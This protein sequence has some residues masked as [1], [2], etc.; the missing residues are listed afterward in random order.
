MT[1]TTRPLRWFRKAFLRIGQ[2]LL[3][4]WG[5]LAIYYSNLPWA[6]ARVAL[7]AAFGAFAVWALWVTRRPRVRWVFAGV[8]GAVVI[9]EIS[10]PPSNDR[11]WRREVAV[12][13]RAVIEGDRVRLTRFRNFAYRSADDFDV[14]YEEREISLAHLVSVDLFVSYWMPGPVAHTF[15]SFDFDDGTPPVCISIE[16]RPEVGETFDPIA[17][18]FKQ[19]ELIYVVGDERDIVRVRTE[20]RGEEVY[21][22]RIRATPDAVRRL[23]RIY[24]DRINELADRPEWY[25][26]LSNNCTLNILRYSRAAGRR[27]SRFDH[28]HLLNGLIDR[29]VYGTGVVDT[30]LSFE[31][32][33]RR[34]HINAAAGAAG[35]A[36][37]FSARIRAGLPVPAAE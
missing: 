19:F 6:W 4:A 34:S 32:L 12:L 5:T 30:R 18:L 27:H 8:F 28:R 24:L 14:R 35:D 29:Y 16:T 33:R 37:D 15:L 36:Q 9:W 25:H 1:R 10:I 26:L 3:I 22:Y 23:F 31:E 13:P 7:A 11:P 20:H 21:L 2:F 17:S